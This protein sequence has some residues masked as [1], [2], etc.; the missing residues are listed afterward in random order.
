MSNLGNIVIIGL[1]IGYA[2]FLI[3]RIILNRKLAK[4]AKE[5]QDIID[6]KMHAVDVRSQKMG[7]RRV[8]A[9]TEF[10]PIYNRVLIDAPCSGL[11]TIASH[12]EIKWFRSQQDLEDQRQKQ[13]EVINKYSQALKPGGVLLYAVCSIDKNEGEEIVKKFL[14]EHADFQ[15][16][17][18]LETPFHDTEFGTYLLP[19]AKGESGYFFSR[20]IRKS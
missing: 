4:D 6:K 11:G 18:D 15:L 17:S 9:V 8:Q 1:V 7:F 10:E 13:T 3:F 19:T 12:P 2:I 14:S 20:L 5:Y 16:D